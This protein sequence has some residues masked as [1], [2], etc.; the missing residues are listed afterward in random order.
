MKKVLSILLAACMLVLFM[1][2]CGN[3]SSEDGSSGSGSPGSSGTSSSSGEQ[4]TL[5]FMRT[6]TPEVLHEIFD[7][8]IEAFE[9][10][11]PNIKID[12]QDLG[13]S[14]AEKTM[15]TMAA[16]KTLPDV[17]YHLPGTIFDLADKGLVLD[18]TS[19]VDDELKEDMYPAMMQ[20][21][22]YDG[23]QYMITCGGTSL[24]LW[25]NADLFKQAGL[26]P[27]N[28]PKTWDEFLDACKALDKL[29]GVDPIGLYAKPS[30]G[31]T[32]F[33]YESLFTTEFGD[34]AWDAGKNQYVYDSDAGKNAAVKTLKFLQDV[35]AYAQDSFVEYGRFDVRTLLR[36]GKV[37]MT[38]D[39]INMANQ[40]PE[41]LE[42]G[43]LRCTSI[44]CGSSGKN[45]TAVNTG[46]WFIPTNSKHPDE[47][48][49]FLRY[50]MRTENQVAH[51][52]YGSVPMLKSEAATYKDGY[53][54]DVIKTMENSYAEGICPQTNAL[55]AV[56]GE[57][58]Q[59]LMMGNQTPE[60][61]QENMAKEHADIYK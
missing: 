19:Y 43:K 53:M 39:A 41:Q 26:D 15:Q 45:S 7:P 17:M 61:T 51:A 52:K 60:Q 34:S 44:P 48:W 23:K 1:A 40:A 47:A 2:G 57:Q 28:P 4:V 16:S 25:Y 5:T 37:A 20:A 18:L 9:K 29:D 36:D 14:D 27:D 30:G 3:S 31:E 38:F 46:G 35:T 22:Q 33:V 10:E 24:I 11:Y 58:L 8:M 42:S 55:W 54:L 56:N 50:M 12:M 49:T 21:G 13:W 6:G 32:S 59:L